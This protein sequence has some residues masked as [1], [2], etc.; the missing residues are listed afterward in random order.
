MGVVALLDD[1]HG[2]HDFTKAIGV[3]FGEKK[4]EQNHDDFQN[5]RDSHDRV[6][7][8]LNQTTLI[9]IVFHHVYT[10]QCGPVGYDGRGGVGLDNAIVILGKEDVISLHGAENFRKK[11]I[12]IRLRIQTV[13]KYPRGLVSN[14][15]TGDLQT[16]HFLNSICDGRGVDNLQT[17][18]FVRSQLTFLNHGGFF[19]LVEQCLADFGAVKIQK[20]QNQKGNDHVD[21]CVTQ[22]GVCVPDLAGRIIS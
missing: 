4:G 3:G 15:Q 21:Q 17:G 13:V 12:I 7:Q 2:I 5:Q 19:T 22:L 16:D 6:L 1:S 18:N 14:D 9:R 20:Q 11:G 10:A 8:R